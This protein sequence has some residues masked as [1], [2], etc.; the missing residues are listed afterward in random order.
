M[1]R[2]S[3]PLERAVGKGAFLDEYRIP[4]SRRIVTQDQ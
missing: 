2:G 1:T 3:V 4:D